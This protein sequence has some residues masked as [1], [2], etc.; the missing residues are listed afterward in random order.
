MA[1]ITII[2]YISYYR[3]SHQALKN[4][5]ESINNLQSSQIGGRRSQFDQNVFEEELLILKA[6]NN[7]AALMICTQPIIYQVTVFLS[8][9]VGLVLISNIMYQKIG[10]VIIKKPT[11]LR[12]YAS[13]CSKQLL[14]FYLI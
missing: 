5:T 10:K 4:S 2:L 6:T 7:F 1:T 11:E 13:H 8:D 14:C 12:I 9:P 3:V